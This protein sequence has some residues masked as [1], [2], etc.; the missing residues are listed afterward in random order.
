MTVRAVPALSGE[1]RPPGD[2]SISHRAAILSSIG[3]GQARLRNF[4]EA[5][6]CAATVECLRCLGVDIEQIENGELAINGAGREGLREPEET[7]DAR[8]SGSTMRMLAG[9]LAG[10]PFL[11]IITGDSSLR[12]RPM[13][14][15]IRPL[16]LMGAHF[17]ARG[18][19][20]RAPLAI[21]G[22]SLKGISYELPVASAQVKTAIMLAALFA[23]GE[24]IIRE[25]VAS[26][27]H[28]ERLLGSMGARIKAGRG[29]IRLE[30]GN[31]SAL[32]LE[33]PGDISS[34]AAWLVAG[35]IHPQAR[36]RAI[37]TGINPGRTGI[38]SVMEE[39]GARIVVRNERV[40]G[41]EPVADIE[42]SSSSLEGVEISGDRVPALI[43]EIPL[44]ALAACYAR[45]RTVIKDAQELRFK[46]TD[47][48][49]ATAEEL[50]KLG[51]DVA[52]LRDGLIING[53]TKL[54]GAFCD[55]HGD[56][57][58]AMM[59]AVAGLVAEGQTEVNNAEVA[60]ISYPG[61]WD[62]VRRYQLC[63]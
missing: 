40:V 34:A 10:Q 16:S 61:F 50:T 36:F 52:E 43:D 18:D 2:K 31:L 7:L 14:R 54:H 4:S 63:D 33:I 11:S 41:G 48:I 45:G 1:I 56:H 30:A 24:T 58:I 60:G 49:S 51:G 17:L 57:R 53:T 46:E 42:T 3:R 12:M 39:M 44:I 47:R 22:G 9:L 15:I 62:E 20:S 25:P 6:D 32:D 23:E 35:A 21:R 28:T 19:G 59:A 55:S 37:G 5:A 8:N 26:R 38:I 29:L 13:E 27:D